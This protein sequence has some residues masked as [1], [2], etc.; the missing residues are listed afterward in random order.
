MDE[1]DIEKEPLKV[2]RSLFLGLYLFHLAFFVLL[3]TM[4]S[5][6]EVG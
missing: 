3:N 4:A 2:G 6:K 5:P 1:E